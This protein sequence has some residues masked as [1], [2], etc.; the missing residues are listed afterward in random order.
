MQINTAEPVSNQLV[1]AILGALASGLM[2]ALLF[3]LLASV[4]AYYA[5]TQTTSRLMGRF[6]AWM[7]G[8]AAAL[9]TAGIAAALTSLVAPAMPT[10]PDLKLQS[11]ASPWAG[12]LMLGF[13]FVPAV[14]VTLFLLSVVD[15][16]TVGWSR[17]I[18]LAA[19]VLMVFGV[20]TSIVSGQ[21][22]RNAL[23]Q[24]IVEGATALLFAWL[25]L[26]YDL[27]TVPAFVETGLILEGVKSASISGTA[28]AWVSLAAA[29]MV[30]IALAWLATRYV[31][32]SPPTQSA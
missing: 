4:G 9:A 28:A 1:I 20:A 26:R 32:S 15:R 21:E 13:A 24:G 3:G 5:R 6:P 22:L 25:V 31:M 16:A 18:L 29:V 23:L 2:V 14:T 10:W 8:M 30:T 12:A 17:R 7:L 19:V 11:F 27:R